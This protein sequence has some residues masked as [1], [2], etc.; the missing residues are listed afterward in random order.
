MGKESEKA[1]VRNKYISFTQ[2]YEYKKQMPPPQKIPWVKE[3]ILSKQLEQMI[4]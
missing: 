2:M 1:G 4:N 3:D